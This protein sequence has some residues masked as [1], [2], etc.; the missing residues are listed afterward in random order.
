MLTARAGPMP[1]TDGH[2]HVFHMTLLFGQE[3]AGEEVILK[4][5]SWTSLYGKAKI[6]KY[7]NKVR[8]LKLF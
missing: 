3:L 5:N 1:H 8:L 4:N 7:V 6:N 2:T